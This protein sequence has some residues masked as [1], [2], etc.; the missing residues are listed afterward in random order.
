[1]AGWGHGSKGTDGANAPKGHPGNI[2]GKAMDDLAKRE[3][4]VTEQ[5]AARLTAVHREAYRAHRAAGGT[6]N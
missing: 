3:A 5:E 1:M 4:Q 6:N 2:S